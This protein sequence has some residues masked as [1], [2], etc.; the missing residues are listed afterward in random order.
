MSIN[1]SVAITDSE[2][3]EV[4]VNTAFEDA[5]KFAEFAQAFAYEQAARLDHMTGGDDE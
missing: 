5:D 4:L 2:S 3:H 1:I